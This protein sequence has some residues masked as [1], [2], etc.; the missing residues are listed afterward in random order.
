ALESHLSK[1]GLIEQRWSEFAERLDYLPMDAKD[2]SSYFHLRQ[3]L[4]PDIS[5]RIFYFAT[6]SDL[7]AVISESLRNEGLADDQTKIVLEKPIGR[8]LATARRSEEHT[9]EL[10]SRENLVCR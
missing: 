1:G 5:N 6:R 2:R 4:N 7:Y 3:K 9:S 10:Q 8:D